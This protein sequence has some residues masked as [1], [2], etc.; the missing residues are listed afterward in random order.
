[1][2]QLNKTRI[3][4]VLSLI[5]CALPARAQQPV[6]GL[7]TTP[8]V[9]TEQFSRE[10]RNFLGREIAAHVADIHSLDPP[11]DRVVGALTTG[12][13]SWG[14]FMRTLA[15]YSALSGE[16]RVAGRDVPQLIGQMG[17]IESKNGGKSFAQLYS[18]LALRHFGTDLGTNP[19]W[20]SLNT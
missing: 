4:I 19:V 1:V 16:R 18:A 3:V 8:T 15:I 11:Q 14:T 7:H 9:S 6:A 2:I 20:Q 12:E 17:L 13:F 5:A 10:M